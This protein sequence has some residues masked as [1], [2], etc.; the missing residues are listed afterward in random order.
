MRHLAGIATL[1]VI[2]S[3]VFAATASARHLVVIKVKS[4]TLVGTVKDVPPKGLSK[5]DRY[6]GQDKLVNLI[7]QFGRK[8]GA[9]IGTDSS[10]LT[11]TGATTGCVTGV[12]KLPGGT[13][14]IKGCARLGV[15]VPIPVV[16]G[17]GA[18]AG[19]RGTMTAGPGNSPPNTYRLS[20]P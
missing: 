7:E 3:G 4:L 5:G 6:T 19:A 15:G 1:F 12:A 14:S 9:L 8:A 2:T 11:L 18:F 20:L 13:I 17:T 16:G 10:T